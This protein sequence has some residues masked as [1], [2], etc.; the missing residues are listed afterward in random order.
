M[1]GLMRIYTFILASSV[2][3]FSAFAGASC[4]Q[5]DLAGLWEIRTLGSVCQVRID[6]EGVMTKAE[7]TDLGFGRYKWN[8]FDGNFDVTNNCRVQARFWV[9]EWPQDYAWRITDS[10]T[11]PDTQYWFGHIEEPLLLDFGEGPE[12]LYTAESFTVIRL[13]RY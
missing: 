2:L 9:N 10:R 12:L 8:W 3:F 6:E 11:R 13:L 1:S 7:C 4:A 5:S